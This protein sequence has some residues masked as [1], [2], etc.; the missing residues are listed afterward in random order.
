MTYS[1]V[2]L[3]D[4][5]FTVIT[6]LYFIDYSNTKFRVTEI[7]VS[8]VREMMKRLEILSKY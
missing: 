6:V 3:R 7:T 4:V 5:I 2:K 1:S 8:G